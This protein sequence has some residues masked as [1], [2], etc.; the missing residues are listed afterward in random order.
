MKK[1][2]ISSIILAIL[3]SILFW[4]QDF[5]ISVPIFIISALII[6]AMILAEH[7]K[8]KNKLG[9]I[10]LIPIILLSSTYFIFDNYFFKAANVIAIPALVFSMIIWI[11]D[12]KNTFKFFVNKVIAILFGGFEFFDKVINS[13]KR[14]KNKEKK[15]NK[16]WRI[17]RAVLISL[18]LV[19][20]VML[21]LGSADSIFGNIFGNVLNGIFENLFIENIFMFVMRIGF[22]ILFFF[23]FAGSIM[24]LISEKSMYTSIDETKKEAELKVNRFNINVTLTILNIIY[25]IFSV[26]QFIYLFTKAGIGED[27]NYAEYARQGFF[28]LMFVTFINFVMIFI[29]HINKGKP[30][31]GEDVLH[32]S[33]D[34]NSKKYAKYMNILMCVFTV[35]IIL[36]SFFRMNLYEQEYGY[37]YLRL[38]V[39]FILSVELL[40]SVPTI[41]YILGIKLPLF[42]TYIIIGTA[43]YV[44]LNFINIDKVIAKKNID[45]YFENPEENR[46]DVIYLRSSTGVDAIGE[47]ERL[48][49]VSDEDIKQEAYIYFHDKRMGMETDE[50]ISWQEYNL[51]RAKARKEIERIDGSD[52]IINKMYESYMEKQAEESRRYYSDLYDS[53]Y[54]NYSYP[55]DYSY[56]NNTS[57]INYDDYGDIY[58]K[59]AKPNYAW[60]FSNRVYTEYTED[61]RPIYG[62]DFNLSYNSSYDNYSYEDGMGETYKIKSYTLLPDRI[63]IKT[64]P[65]K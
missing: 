43:M 65:R 19:I 30:E 60:E 35:I 63:V 45:R 22:A 10:L 11:T 55:Y 16:V 25:L 34:E 18:P 48:L 41:M 26:I 20:V 4:G 7:K 32:P 36:S 46:I 28:Q 62:F 1:I 3:Q 42:K 13:L 33:S 64:F 47:M 61:T 15:N 44:A 51:S 29:S 54:Y 50:E 56:D 31:T 38:F 53:E 49:Y 23:Y 12:E 5:G 52:H 6:L 57:I 14:D 9:L 37:T 59:D 40:L 21:L 27:F 17:V 58:T 2:L 39:Y 24:N 8:I